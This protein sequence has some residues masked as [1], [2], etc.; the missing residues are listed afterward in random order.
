MVEHLP[1]AVQCIFTSLSNQFVWA[2][3]RDEYIAGSS[4]DLALRYGMA[5]DGEWSL[6]GIVD[7][8]PAD[9]GT[10]QTFDPSVLAAIAGNA[11]AGEIAKVARI[12]RAMGRPW[13]A[14]G[15]TPLLIFREV[16]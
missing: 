2:L 1:H 14:F 5:I 8:L 6:L 13:N 12:A 10:S 4:S 11:I 3:L 16:S 9:Q 7:A 15:L